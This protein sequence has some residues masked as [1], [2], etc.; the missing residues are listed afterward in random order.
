[1]RFVV[2]VLAIL[3]SPLPLH[4][5][6]AAQSPQTEAAIADARES[7]RRQILS[8]TVTQGLTVRELTD[9]TGSAPELN[10][11]IDGAQQ[12]GGTRW[13]D[14]QTAQVRLV[15]EG[16]VIADCLSR[17]VAKDPSKASIQPEALRRALSEW[18]NRSYAA[19]GTS[20]GPADVTRLQPPAGDVN[21]NGVPQADRN[22]A[23][24]AAR[25]SAVGRMTDSLRPIELVDGKTINDALGVPEVNS[26]LSDWLTNRPVTSVEF[27]DDLSVRIAMSVPPDE[28]WQVLHGA[29]SHQK[30]VPTPSTESGWSLLQ[31]Q[32]E[33]RLAQ[34][35]GVG[36]VQV[37]RGGPQV[38]NLLPDFAPQWANQQMQAE[39]TSPSKGS[40]L[41]TARAAE[42]IAMEKLRGQVEALKLRDNRTVG[43]AER[44]DAR[45]ERAV[46]KALGR[47]HPYQVDYGQGSVTVRVTFNLSDLWTLLSER[48]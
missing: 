35:V 19:T 10:K 48:R 12:I 24:A 8:A 17:A 45:V 37:A 30:Q 21:W 4:A 32:V 1:M 43:Q 39:G 7:L 5:Q 22:R 38:E 2:F 33:S 29:L 16:G 41:H 23:L 18:R 36:L 46:A 3:A 40:K 9:R 25:E 20:T 42:A 14:D 26:A 11:S 15:I 13:L 44:R 6:D 47:A 27:H 31:K 28:L 34:P